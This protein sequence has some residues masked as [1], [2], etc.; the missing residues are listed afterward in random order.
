MQCSTNIYLSPGLRWVGQPHAPATW[1][2]DGPQ[3]QC[4]FFKEEEFLSSHWES[5]HDSPF[6][7]FITQSLHYIYTTSSVLQVPQH[8]LN[9]LKILITWND[10]F[11]IWRGW[12][13]LGF[14]TVLHI[15]QGKS[16][17][18]K[19]DILKLTEVNDPTHKAYR[20]IYNPLLH[21]R[22]KI[23]IN[24]LKTMINQNYKHTTSS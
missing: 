8:I 13:T 23:L 4:G 24:A 18:K 9:F 15:D 21:D 19:L 6:A 3:S 2:M 11:N 20:K 5:N 22:V 17:D 16:D 1:P 7:Q 10:E 12:S 14:K